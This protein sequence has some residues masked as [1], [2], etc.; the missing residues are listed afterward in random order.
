MLNRTSHK[1]QN[2]T[3]VRPIDNL[4]CSENMASIQKVVDEIKGACNVLQV[5][6]TMSLAGVDIVEVR[7]SLCNSICSMI[8]ALHPSLTPTH[9][10]PVLTAIAE[11]CFKDEEKARM[12]TSLHQ[13]LSAAPSVDVLAPHERQTFV[14][15]ESVLNYYT[16]DDWKVFNDPQ[17]PFDSDIK[18]HCAIQRLVAGGMYKMS[19]KTLADIT[20]MLAGC[21]HEVDNKQKLYDFVWKLKGIMHTTENTG[22]NLPIIRIYPDD[23]RSL[24]DAHKDSMYGH[25]DARQSPINATM[26][27]FNTVRNV[28]SIR[29]NNKLL[30]PTQ[31]ALQ[32]FPMISNNGF[33]PMGSMPRAPHMQHQQHPVLQFANA[34]GMNPLQAMQQMASIMGGFM[35]NQN[36]PQSQTA[37]ILPDMQYNIKS[38]AP[39]GTTPRRAPSPPPHDSPQDVTEADVKVVPV[40][41]EQSGAGG[42]KPDCVMAALNEIM[43]KPRKP[44]TP[45][46]DISHDEPFGCDAKAAAVD[47]AAMEAQ[48]QAIIA[49]HVN[50]ATKADAKNRAALK[51]PASSLEQRGASAPAMLDLKKG[52]TSVL[53]NGGKIMASAS[54][55]CWRVWT[56]ASEPA[57]KKKVKYGDDMKKSWTVACSHLKK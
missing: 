34:V 36:Q 33:T 18:A 46:S 4:R 2:L 40:V 26:L 16:E 50:N 24:S 14:K 43:A 22:A 52:P 17:Q 23:P 9:A 1:Q 32:Q 28:V 27:H 44:I 47:V 53:W 8:D 10:A 5:H 20:A 45:L 21:R 56:N 6:T 57:K 51:R 42:S 37:D 49:K 15:P 35:Q 54:K 31:D 11:S 13:K 55:Q 3:L 41:G 12:A 38:G 7:T 29:K 30:R 48:H 19:D 39:S 25:G